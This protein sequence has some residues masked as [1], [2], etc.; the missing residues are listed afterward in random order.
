MMTL[1]QNNPKILIKYARFL[2]PIFKAYV[3][4]DPRWKNV[5]VPTEDDVKE[6][7]ARYRGEW[8]RVGQKMLEGTC[9]V[10][11]LSFDRPVIDVYV[12]S[13]NPRPFSDPI[14]IKS[15]HE[16]REFPSV[17]MHELTH[18]LFTINIDRVYPTIFS[19]MFPN[20]TTTT[21]NHVVVH[22]VLKYLYLDTLNDD[23]L[24]GEH[25]ER[26]KK[27]STAE[28]VRAWDIVQERGYREIIE[29]FKKNYKT[30]Q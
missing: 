10:L 8:E 25:I 15:G 14:V 6:R 13:L 24:L 22:A 20:E 2:D 27:H 19:D 17:L 26:S 29:E 18:R 21:Q 7:I 4:S 23:A 28:Y 1:P 12:V 3:A 5:A 16:P 30:V 9:E 11:G